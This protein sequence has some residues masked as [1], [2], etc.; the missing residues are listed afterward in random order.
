MDRQWANSPSQTAQK[1]IKSLDNASK[2]NRQSI[3]NS[4]EEHA[5]QSKKNPKQI[6]HKIIHTDLSKLF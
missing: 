6:A 4:R 2:R 3:N 5:R 1:V